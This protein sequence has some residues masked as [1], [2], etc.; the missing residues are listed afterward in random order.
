MALSLKNLNVGTIVD[1]V[2][3]WGEDG[4]ERPLDTIRRGLI[5][6]MEGSPQEQ[7]VGKIWVTYGKGHGKTTEIRGKKIDVVE[8]KASELVEVYDHESKEARIAWRRI[9]GM[10]VNVGSEFAQRKNQS[11]RKIVKDDLALTPKPK[12]A[13]VTDQDD[14]GVDDMEL[15]ETQA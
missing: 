1:R 5:V 10:P 13:V 2:S 7:N 4:K 15:P 3:E 9:F 12:D 6:K 8:S 11:R 14:L